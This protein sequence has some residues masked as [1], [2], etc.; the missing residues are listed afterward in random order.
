MQPNSPSFAVNKSNKRPILVT[1]F[2]SN[3]KTVIGFLDPNMEEWNTHKKS[4]SAIFVKERN[5]SLHGNFGLGYRGSNK[6]R[7]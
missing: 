6:Q 5:L 7:H 3:C 1:T 2:P 4:S